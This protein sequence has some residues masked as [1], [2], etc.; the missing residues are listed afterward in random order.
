MNPD[1]TVHISRYPE[2]EWVALAAQSHYQGTGRG[3]AEGDMFDRKGWLGR[4][5]QSLYL[6]RL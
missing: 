1:L 5:S 2:G 6:D 3:V 4:S